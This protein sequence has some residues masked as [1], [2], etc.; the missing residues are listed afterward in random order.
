[1][2]DLIKENWEER[3]SASKSAQINHLN[4]LKL[5]NQECPVHLDTS[6]IEEGELCGAVHAGALGEPSYSG[7]E[8]RGS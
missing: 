7:P 5:W 2:L 6:V 1:V 3:P 8:N 4:L